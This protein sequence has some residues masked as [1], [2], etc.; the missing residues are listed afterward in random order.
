MKKFAFVLAALA[1]VVFAMPV[2]SANA[3]MRHHHHHHHHHM[4][5]R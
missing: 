1:A 2:T 5:H 4:M 3:G